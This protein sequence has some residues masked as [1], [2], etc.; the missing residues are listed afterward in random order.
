MNMCTPYS[1][2]YMAHPNKNVY[3]ENKTKNMS[4]LYVAEIK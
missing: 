1:S 4:A 3:T 2:Y